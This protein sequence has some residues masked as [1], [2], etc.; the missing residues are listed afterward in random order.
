VRCKL[1]FKENETSVCDS[2]K[3]K[4]LIAMELGV[5]P[6]NIIDSVRDANM[7]SV[8]IGERKRQKVL[9]GPQSW[10]F[11]TKKERDSCSRAL[12]KIRKEC[13]TMFKDKNLSWFHIAKEELWEAAEAETLN[14]QLEEILQTIAVLFSAI[15]NIVDRES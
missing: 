15:Y 10:E 5:K 2:C 11:A 7:M 9:H 3:E 13:D 6:F 12:P 4:F 1:C 8:I 14:E